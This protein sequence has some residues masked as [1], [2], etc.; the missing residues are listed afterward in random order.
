MRSLKE[1][2]VVPKR[3][4]E[5]LMFTSEE[6]TRF[7]IGCLGSRLLGGVLDES[8]DTL[9]DRLPE[10]EPHATSGLTLAEVREAAGFHG[11]LSGVKL[12][13]GYYDAWVEQ[14]IE[15]GPL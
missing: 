7:G 12:P 15:Q 11:P 10:T 4:I 3:S 5:L 9:P 2:G 13:K 1:A 8:A 6:P 14:H